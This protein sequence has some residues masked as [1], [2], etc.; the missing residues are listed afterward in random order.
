M[1]IKI[2]DMINAYNKHMHLKNAAD[3]LGM[4]WQTLYWHLQKIGFKVTGNK[5]LYGSEKDKLAA[6]SELDFKRIVPFAKSMNNEKF[7]SKYDFEVNGAT[8]DVKSSLKNYQNKKKT[9]KRFAFS[10]KKQS[11]YVDYIVCFGYEAESIDVI[12]LIPNNVFNGMH[13]ISVSLTK[14]IYDKYKVSEDELFNFFKDL[15]CEIKY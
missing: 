14:S 9:V 11:S 12:L 1:N 3:E 2:E 7:Q 8:V 15:K 4:K 10:V 13:T 6:K 5:E